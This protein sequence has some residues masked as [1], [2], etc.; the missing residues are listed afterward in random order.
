MAFFKKMS[1][2]VIFAQGKVIVSVALRLLSTVNLGFFTAGKVEEHF[3]IY[4]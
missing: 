2:L 1:S 4:I 3:F